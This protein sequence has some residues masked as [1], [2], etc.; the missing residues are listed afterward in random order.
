M[1]ENIF[2]VGLMLLGHHGKRCLLSKKMLGINDLREPTR[3]WFELVNAR[4][5]YSAK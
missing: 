1:I 3:E 5:G 2:P 4:L